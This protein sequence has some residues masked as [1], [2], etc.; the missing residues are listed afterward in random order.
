[1]AIVFFLFQIIFMTKLL[2]VAFRAWVQME[3]IFPYSESAAIAL[4]QK[5][6]K[7]ILLKKSIEEMKHSINELKKKLRK[8][9]QSRNA[10]TV[11]NKNSTATSKITANLPKADVMKSKRNGITRIET[12]KPSARIL[13]SNSQR[14]K[15]RSAKK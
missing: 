14:A 1:M 11:N 2:I 3:H 13:R 15:L 6:P 4:A 12:P 7:N 5:H 9:V 10:V 8:T